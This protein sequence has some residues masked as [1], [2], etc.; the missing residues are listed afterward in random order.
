MHELSITCAKPG[1]F[2]SQE[3]QHVTFSR[4]GVCSRVALFKMVA[5]SLMGDTGI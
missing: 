2:P 3:V 1:R 5:T 4:R